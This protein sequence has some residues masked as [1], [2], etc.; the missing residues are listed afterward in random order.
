MDSLKLDR[1]K[2][3]LNRQ[4]TSINLCDTTPATQTT[5]NNNNNNAAGGPTTNATITTATITTAS[6]P[7]SSHNINQQQTKA[8]TTTITTN[9]PSYITKDN[10][11]PANFIARKLFCDYIEIVE[12]KIDAILAQD[13]S[14]RDKPIFKTL[15]KDVDIYYDQV[16]EGLNSISE[17]C[18]P[19]LLNLFL[20]WYH[21]QLGKD[22]SFDNSL[23]RRPQSSLDNPNHSI[24]QQHS[25]STSNC[26]LH[27]QEC[28]GSP[29]NTELHSLNTT[30]LTNE[31]PSISLLRS[32]T[33]SS[34][35]ATSNQI[36][37]TS[38][39]SLDYQSPASLTTII[40]SNNNTINNSTHLGNLSNIAN[41]TLQTNTTSSTANTSTSTATN[42]SSNSLTLDDNPTNTIKRL[43]LIKTRKLL[44]E[45]AFCQALIEIFGKLCLHPG[46]YDLISQIEDIAFDHFKPKNNNRD[47][48]PPPPPPQTGVDVADINRLADKFAEV[49]GILSQTRFR[50][51]KKRFFIE[52]NELRSREP[53]QA[54][55]QAISTLLMSMKYFRVK[56][57]PIEEFEASFQFLQECADYFN[58]L[59]H[60]SI[61]HALADLFVE[62]M[63]PLASTVKNEVKIPC[64]KNF[65]D[66]LWG[67]TLD[68]CARKKHSVTL[69]PLVT[70]LLCVSQRTIFLQNW[71]PFLQM[72]LSNLKNRDQKMCRISL[73]SL[74]RL[75]WVYM[76]RVKCESNNVTQT[77]L[78]SI[79]DGLFPRGS[80]QV[81]PRETPLNIFVDIIQFIAQERLDFA[82]RHII[83]ELV[84]VDRPVKMIVAPERMNIGLQAFLVIADNLQQKDGEPT[85]PI[86]IDL[87]SSQ[88]K[89]SFTPNS[90]SSM[91]TNNS[92][93]STS[94]PSSSSY[95]S[96]STR[97]HHAHHHHHHNQ[98]HHQPLNNHNHVYTSNHHHTHDNNHL[99]NS[100]ST[101]SFCLMRKAHHVQQHK[102]L[103]D[104]IA[105]SIGLHPYYNH[106]QKSFNE[107][108]KALDAQFGRPLM[109]TTT[110]GQQQQQHHQH[111]GHHQ[112]S[113]SKEADESSKMLTGDRKPKVDLFK[114]CIAAIPRLMPDGMSKADL[115]DL[116][117]RMTV[118]IDEEMRKYAFESLQTLVTDYQDWRLE[119][120]EGFTL[121]I[122][123][124]IDE[125]LRSLV[126]NALRML[127]QLLIS[128][129][130]IITS[131][132]SSSA[133]SQ[134]SWSS[135]F[136]SSS[137]CD[138]ARSSVV[139]IQTGYE[140]ISTRNS[141][142]GGQIVARK[143]RALAE[144]RLIQ[145]ELSNTRFD[146]LVNVIQKVEGAS[147]VMLCSCHQPTRKLA[148]L[149]LRECRT[150]LKCYSSWTCMEQF[151]LRSPDD[152][153][154][155]DLSAASLKGSL[156]ADNLSRIT[157]T[158]GAYGPIHSSVTSMNTQALLSTSISKMCISSSSGGFGARMNSQQQQQQQHDLYDEDV[159]NNLLDGGDDD[160]DENNGRG[161]SNLIFW[162]AVMMLESDKEQEY[163][164]ALNLLKKLLPNMPFE[165]AEF[166][167][168]LERNL[169]QMGWDNFP[170]I[171]ALV[172]KGCASSATYDLCI[173][174]L[175]HLTPIMKH[176]ICT[177]S[178]KP[179]NCLPFHILILS[180]H[181]LCNYEDPT[182]F[183]LNVARR[184][185]LCCEENS[186]K[187]ENLAAVL[188]L[189]SRRSFSKDSFQWI[190]CVAKYLHDAC[191]DI[192]PN[193]IPLLVDL[194]E[195]G[196]CQVQRL[197]APILYCLFSYIDINLQPSVCFNADLTRIYNKC[198]SSPALWR[199]A[200]QLYK[201]IISKS[202]SL[203]NE[204]ASSGGSGGAGGRELPGRTMDFSIEVE[205]LPV[206]A[207]AR[208]GEFGP[209][210]AS[211]P[212]N[213]SLSS[214]HQQ[215]PQQSS[216]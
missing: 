168:D 24:Q 201:L 182:P 122:A 149:L 5:S 113:S 62:I 12:K 45:Y 106:I 159:E 26:D 191:P 77:R 107:I 134:L 17:Y 94:T 190:K 61:K 29:C 81:V 128:W 65:V 203:A 195:T 108:L 32:P 56:M 58:E 68:M 52:L 142:T 131:S 87:S 4:Y 184:L 92:R 75:I 79:V 175:D 186:Q 206:I 3:L 95:H 187:L 13:Q 51:V 71:G 50:L 30:T 185:A 98:N 121:F 192:L 54:N 18:L 210:S 165:R 193:V 25:S 136:S 84:S 78:Q 8:P 132:S 64:L 101:S 93:G 60:K 70:C 161:S 115:I 141:A 189:Y 183:S 129:R 120:I 36:S 116:L 208:L 119:A 16:L 110:L 211:T 69:F 212:G 157:A 145:S 33:P 123:N 152:V 57:A 49:L 166:L 47:S 140:T 7:P 73:E 205:S 125:S 31:S 138:S 179:E 213:L 198:L 146:R 160:D 48:S 28:C 139:T 85:M 162:I 53:T 172:L 164:F 147:L 89:L 91:A 80:R 23:T 137:A 180:T 43:E 194:Q 19:S 112:G 207:K 21:Y 22:E 37:I 11:K 176:Y 204:N 59:R 156:S 177:A 148:N 196:P 14:D 174:L 126:D 143:N 86:S 209:A 40:E 158:S 99:N 74:Y 199:D 88:Q 9:L 105:K 55:I 155:E 63:L 103:N 181:L 202:S 124:Q 102:M 173:A 153:E 82:M 6:A 15:Q 109:L 117:S 10:P 127:L 100:N 67:P 214:K 215:Q 1:F 39:L 111:H 46:H 118:H 150:I 163:I 171:H 154:E 130:G 169:Q 216:C 188:L 97:H 135:S 34:P 35:E 76:M 20:E 66:T 144:M 170:G 2:R 90:L 96:T 42:A 133:S 27:N 44:I 104:E 41:D 114:T 72:C 200:V 151:G 197:I 167:D 38:S 83:F 178:T